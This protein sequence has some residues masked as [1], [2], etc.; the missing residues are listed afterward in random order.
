MGRCGKTLDGHP[1][2]G[3]MI[4][5]SISIIFMLINIRLLMN[6]NDESDES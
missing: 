5:L 1:F 6:N 2:A 4:Y 3:A